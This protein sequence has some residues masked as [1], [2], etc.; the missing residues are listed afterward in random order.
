MIVAKLS[1]GEIIDL[2]P[3]AMVEGIN[4]VESGSELIPLK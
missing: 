3:K 2:T 1:N 4:S